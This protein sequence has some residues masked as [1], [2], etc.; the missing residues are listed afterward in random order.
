MA[1]VMQLSS[2]YYNQTLKDFPPKRPF[3]NKLALATER[4]PLLE[5]YLSDIASNHTLLNCSLSQ[6]LF[7]FRRYVCGDDGDGGL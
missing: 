1:M 5:E 4:Q 6:Q 3:S 7:E 2:K